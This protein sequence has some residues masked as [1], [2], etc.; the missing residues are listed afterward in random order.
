MGSPLNGAAVEVDDLR[1]A[2]GA[3]LALGITVLVTRQ[4]LE[5]ADTLAD[6]VVI[7]SAGKVA[8]T[9]TPAQL[10]AR[11]GTVRF[12]LGFAGPSV[13]ETASLALAAGGY[14]PDRDGAGGRVRSAAA[15]SGC[16]A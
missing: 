3:V 6:Q 11:L 14:Q 15:R 13:A 9:G 10:K 8:G 16:P 12:D 4:Y 2:F 5:E 1:K 7:I